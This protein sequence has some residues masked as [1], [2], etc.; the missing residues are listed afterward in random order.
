ME[1]PPL[2][3]VGPHVGLGRDPWTC[4]ALLLPIMSALVFCT[5]MD[6]LVSRLGAEA[7]GG[8]LELRL[9]A[10]VRAPLPGA[11][12]LRLGLT[13][14][15]LVSVSWCAAVFCCSGRT[16]EALESASLGAGVRRWS[17]RI[18]LGCCTVCCGCTECGISA[19]LCLSAPHGAG[20]CAPSV[21]P[22]STCAALACGKCGSLGSA[23]VE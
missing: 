15:T 8:T 6:A 13:W 2:G 11:V 12:R 18:W 21:R 3:R 22:S 17:R 19:T 1:A 20:V 14:D 4:A 7:D 5:P 9:G 10:P 23:A 16:C